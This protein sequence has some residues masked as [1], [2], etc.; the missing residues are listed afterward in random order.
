MDGDYYVQVN[1]DRS[2]Q[3]PS[4][5]GFLITV[6]V[7]GDVEPGPVY[8]TTG[9]GDGCTW[10][11]EGDRRTGVDGAALVCTLADGS[12]QWRVPG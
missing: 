11:Q 4:S 12:Y 6:V 5:T 7:S 1:A 10:Q 8:Q 2:E 3:E 9:A